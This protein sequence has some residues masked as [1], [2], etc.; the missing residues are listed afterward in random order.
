M[1]SYRLRLRIRYSRLPSVLNLQVRAN[2]LLLINKVANTRLTVRIKV[3]AGILSKGD[4]RMS[5][6]SQLRGI[7]N[8]RYTFGRCASVFMKVMWKGFQLQNYWWQMICEQNLSGWLLPHC[9]R[10][11]PFLAVFSAYESVIEKAT[12]IRGSV[13]WAALRKARCT[14]RTRQNVLLCGAFVNNSKVHSSRTNVWCA[15]ANGLSLLEL[16]KMDPSKLYSESLFHFQ[17]PGVTL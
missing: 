10:K 9:P 8:L 15:C 2:S 13:R 12:R 17:Q 4:D 3:E 16:S 5:D 6:L 14:L 7:K 1:L 11:V